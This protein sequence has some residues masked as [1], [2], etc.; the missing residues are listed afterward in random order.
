LDTL[1]S[2][3]D[4]I[5][6]VIVVLYLIPIFFFNNIYGIKSIVQKLGVN[7]QFFSPINYLLSAYF[8]SIFFGLNYF[9]YFSLTIGLFFYLSFAYRLFKNRSL[10]IKLIAQNIIL[11]IFLHLALIDSIIKVSPG[12]SDTFNNF[13]WLKFYKLTGE[14]AEYPTLWLNLFIPLYSVEM[15]TISF[16]KHSNLIASLVGLFILFTVTNTFFSIFLHK[17]M[18]ISFALLVTPELIRIII[19]FYHNQFW[20]LAFIIFIKILYDSTRK[21]NNVFTFPIYLLMLFVAVE[22]P[23]LLL[24]ILPLLLIHVFYLKIIIRVEDKLIRKSFY[25]FC[26]TISWVI[27]ANT[28]ILLGIDRL[29][30][31]NLEDRFSTSKSLFNSYYAILI[32]DDAVDKSRYMWMFL[33][34]CIFLLF[35]YILS[36]LEANLISIT[37]KHIITTASLIAVGLNFSISL[38]EPN[39]FKGRYIWNVMLITI[40]LMTYLGINLVNKMNYKIQLLIYS[41]LFL[42]TIL[43]IVAH[44]IYHSRNISETTWKFVANNSNLKI[45]VYKKLLI[46]VANYDNVISSISIGVSAY[47]INKPINLDSNSTYVL[48][49]FFDS[50]CAT[51]KYRFLTYLPYEINFVSSDQITSFIE[52]SSKLK[53]TDFEVRKLDC[54]LI[55]TLN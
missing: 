9:N 22:I 18:F 33:S 53:S 16:L 17:M 48:P 24:Y 26:F 32:T 29:S 14:L 43:V 46:P 36:K 47:E 12:H 10:Q 7:Q 21:K 41:V 20:P 52:L 31:I 35:I 19:S 51:P 39:S 42:S 38:I 28:K 37:K 30:Q 25:L 4:L 44:P 11:I 27:V 55:Y 54:I 23:L 34:F 40:V 15:L 45:V 8:F 13:E 6:Y 2:N 3:V 49:N 50:N 1:L 5:T